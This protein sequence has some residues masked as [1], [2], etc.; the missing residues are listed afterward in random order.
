[1]GEQIAIIWSAC[2]RDDLQ[3]SLGNAGRSSLSVRASIGVVDV[4]INRWVWS[5]G[6]SFVSGILPYAVLQLR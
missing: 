1:M 4:H 6:P 5:G 3:T 2:F